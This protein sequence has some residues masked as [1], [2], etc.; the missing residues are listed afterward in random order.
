LA[1]G[2]TFVGCSVATAGL[3]VVG[4]GAAAGAVGGAVNAAWDCPGKTAAA[5]A[6][7]VAIG[8]GSG[9]AAGAVGGLLGGG[10]G[11]GALLGTLRSGFAGYAAGF[12]ESVTNQA[13]SIGHVDLG[14]AHKVG[15]LGGI[16]GGTLH[17][18]GTGFRGVQSSRA[19]VPAT[20]SPT[21]APQTARPPLFSQTTASP[22]FKNG[23]FA[24]QSIGDVAGGLRAGKITPDQLPI[25]VMSRNGEMISLNTRSTLALR[26]AGIDPSDWV[27]NDVTGVPSMEQLLTERLARNGLSGGTDVL[28]ITGAGPNA[29]SLQ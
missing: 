3:G 20:K 10:V 23:P 1:A 6:K 25:D 13:L 26:R 17:A 29:S 7:G 9:T 4:C 15:I 24:G 5:C 28:R 8:A 21:L 27:L 14:A 2:G 19:P 18:G 16:T 11:G 22:T 12:T